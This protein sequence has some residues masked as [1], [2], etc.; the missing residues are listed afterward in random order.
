MGGF[1]GSIYRANAL[2]AVVSILN[3]LVFFF[4]TRNMQRYSPKEVKRRATYRKEVQAGKEQSQYADGAKHRC[5]VC[6]RTE[7]TNP[8][9]EFRYCSKCNRNHEYCQEHLFTHEHIK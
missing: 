3:F 8:D 2:A 4:A 1:I 9:L 7:L 6:G 5:S